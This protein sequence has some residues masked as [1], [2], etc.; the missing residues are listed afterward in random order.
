MSLSRRGSAIAWRL[1][2]LCAPPAPNALGSGAEAA[3]AAAARLA[4]SPSL[5]ALLPDHDRRRPASSSAWTPAAAYGLLAS[6]SFSA[7]AASDGADADAT[8]AATS[9]LASYG[10]DSLVSL[11]AAAEAAALEA[12]GEDRW[13]TTRALQWLIETVHGSTGLPWWA[14]IMV[15]TAGMRAASF[16]IMLMQIKNTYRLSQ[17]RPEV[18]ALVAHMKEEQ[19]KGNPNATA[20]YQQRVAAVW[21]RTGAN[22]LKSVA[23]LLVQAPLFVGFFSALR[24]MAA[25]KVPSLTEGG[26]L[27]FTDLTVPDATYGLP[28]LA[29]A[30]FLLTVEVG[31]ADGMEGQTAVM[32]KRMKNIM[33]FVSLAIIPFSGNLPA[34]VFMYW[35]AS[36]AFSLAQTLVLRIPGVKPALGIPTLKP[37]GGGGAPAAA[38]PG[39]PL[40]TF[41]QKP[42]PAA[43]EPEPERPAPLKVKPGALKKRHRKRPGPDH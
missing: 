19:A 35:T 6:R 14:S 16:P 10:P 7:G 15:T 21:A 3:T 24:A 12:A 8:D 9:V 36:N 41:S 38:E 25:A 32:Q 37:G 22:P 11:A 30:T 33:R 5:A 31:A 17:A 13:P 42:R 39:K 23:T 2:A 29:A 20:E 43:A 4:A 27:W 26:T 18:E 40:A 34:S 28:L 1:R